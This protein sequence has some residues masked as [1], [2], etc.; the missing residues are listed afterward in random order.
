LGI[1]WKLPEE[2]AIVSGKDQIHP[3]LADAEMNF[4]F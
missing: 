1:D 2:E 4:K 3:F